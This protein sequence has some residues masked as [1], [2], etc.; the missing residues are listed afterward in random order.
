M[1]YHYH[2]EN[3]PALSFLLPLNLLHHQPHYATYMS[4]FINPNKI[5]VQS[6]D[7]TEFI[8]TTQFALFWSL[9]KI[10][11]IGGRSNRKIS[12]SQL[13]GLNILD[14]APLHIT[15]FRYVC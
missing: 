2:L 3:W 9:K 14:Y 4:T 8:G 7:A 11:Q 13:V 1:W 10:F 6:T 15:P 5:G 12:D